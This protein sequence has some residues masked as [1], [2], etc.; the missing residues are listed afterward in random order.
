VPKILVD[1]DACPVKAEIY[2]VAGRRGLKV[3]LVANSNITIP[4]EDWI[5][6][7]VVGNALD[8]ADDWIVEHISK[9]DIVITADIPLASLGFNKGAWIISPRGQ[10]FTASSLHNAAATRDLMTH[11][12]GTGLNT[13]GPSAFSKKDRSCFLQALDNLIRQIIEK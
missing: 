3:V 2:R 4:V 12:R 8:A 7:K 1:A 9:D 11:L 6:L 5:E 13:S 10:V